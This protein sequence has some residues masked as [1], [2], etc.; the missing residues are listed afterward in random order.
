MIMTRPGDEVLGRENVALRALVALYRHLSSLT[1][2]DVGIE[3]VVELIAD[4]V[5]TAVAVVDEELTVLTAAET[6]G[7]PAD[8]ARY[9]LGRLAH[10]RLAQILGTA[11]PARRALRL[12]AVDGAAPIIVAPIAVG[13]AVAAYLLTMDDGEQGDGED[14]RLLIT[15]HAATV[16]GLILGRERM[17]AAAATRVRHDLVEGLLSGL[18]SDPDEVRRWAAHLGY[19]EGEAHR[20]MSIVLRDGCE[21]ADTATRISEAV[22]RFFTI[23]YPEAITAV[24]G[25]EV[26]VVLPE[27]E[28]ESPRARRL[29]DTC[30]GRIREVFPRAAMTVGIGGLCRSALEIARSYEDARRTVD[31]VGRMRR[32]A[33]VV[34]V[35]DLGVHRL[36]LQVA[37][38]A[39]LRGFA[40]EVFGALLAQAKNN[41]REYLSTLACY[42]RENNSPQRASQEL[43]VHPNTVTY[44]VRRVEEMTGLDFRS[45]R[46]RLMAQI[47]LEIFDVVGDGS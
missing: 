4:R 35:E 5:D 31:I 24:R 39:Q 1:V 13:D 32:S 20:V 16:C 23:R 38:P 11:G 17:V 19:D 43:H 3:A 12:P 15:E 7:S 29:A 2:Q 8:V 33:A 10:P 30:V 6:G 21:R 22:E 47:A 44:R 36:L 25:S 18:G 27:P 26:A 37:N 40:D 46:D 14:L 9:F 45:Y 34:A 28:P 41:T 42:F